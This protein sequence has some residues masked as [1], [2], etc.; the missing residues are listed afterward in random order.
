MTFYKNNSGFIALTSVIFISAFFVI[1]FAGMFFSA[2][3]QIERA[4]NREFASRALSLANSCAEESLNKLKNSLGYEGDDTITVGSE[5]CEVLEMDITDT[6]RVIKS[7]GEVGGHIKR[8][9][10]DVDVHNHP[11]I[12][13]M[14]WRTVPFFSNL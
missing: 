3:S 10:V 8:V 4:D 13:I 5:T 9:Q 6:A 12:E 2:V 7:K 11:Y 1:I 14:D